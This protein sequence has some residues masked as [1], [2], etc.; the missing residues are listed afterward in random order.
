MNESDNNTRHLVKALYIYSNGDTVERSWTSTE[1]SGRP[2]NV[3]A[4]E[5]N[6]SVREYSSH[7]QIFLR[8][9]KGDKKTLPLSRIFN[10]SIKIISRMLLFNQKEGLKKSD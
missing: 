10:E 9:K 8:V 1:R 6:G 3:I 4:C 7:Y 5:E 2:I